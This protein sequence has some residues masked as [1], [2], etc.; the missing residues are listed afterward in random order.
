MSNLVLLE[1]SRWIP[2]YGLAG[3][4][5]A[6]PWATGWVKYSGPRPA[7]YLNIVL[8]LMALAHGVLVLRQVW[9]HAPYIV[10]YPWF[11]VADLDLSLSLE[12]SPLSMGAVVW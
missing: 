11:R 6:L 9:G 12:I 10:D 8:T 2:F 1:S 5:L 7:A 3:A 4:A